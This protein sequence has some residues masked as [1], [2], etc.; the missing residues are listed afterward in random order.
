MFFEYWLILLFFLFNI[1]TFFLF[2]ND[3]KLYRFNCL[4]HLS[5]G[6]ADFTVLEPEDLVAA[7]AYNEYNILITNELR[8]FSD[9]NNKVNQIVI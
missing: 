8:L 3:I 1:L 5:M 4:R 6:K 9:G 7:S 2:F